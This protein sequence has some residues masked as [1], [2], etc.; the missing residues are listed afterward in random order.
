MHCSPCGRLRPKS[1][2]GTASCAARRRAGVYIRFAQFPGKGPPRAAVRCRSVE[3]CVA[4]AALVA[5]RCQQQLLQHCRLVASCLLLANHHGE[6]PQARWAAAMGCACAAARP[7]PGY[8]NIT[9]GAKSRPW[10][11]PP[12]EAAR[13]AGPRCGTVHER[14]RRAP[15][16]S[17]PTWAT[18]GTLTPWMRSSARG[19]RAA[20][21]KAR[22]C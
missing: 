5:E 17:P 19:R 12:R 7:A 22:G 20:K 2:W 8:Q 16:G 3:A 15:L 14:R 9:C 10:L 6:A 13:P 21:W 1:C 11:P 18:T 4:L